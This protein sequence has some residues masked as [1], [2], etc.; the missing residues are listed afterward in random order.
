MQKIFDFIRIKRHPVII[1]IILLSIALILETIEFIASVALEGFLFENLFAYIFDL[2]VNGFIVMSLSFKNVALIEVGLIVIKT[3]DGT[4]YP[5][6]SCQRL[7]SIILNGVDTFYL[8]NHIL[9]AASAFS[10]LIALILFCIYKVNGQMKFW[11]VMK[12]VVLIC[13]LLMFTSSVLYIIALIKGNIT[14]EE[15]LEPIYLTCMFVGVYAACEYI[16][17][18]EHRAKKANIA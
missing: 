14:W 9:F 4:Y 13:S 15:V 6:R 16:E 2:F 11:E 5:L 18:V 7:D 17:G 12:I 3:F 10:L 1:G 8:V